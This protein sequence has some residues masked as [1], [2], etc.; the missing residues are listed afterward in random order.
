MESSAKSP[1][2]TMRILKY[3]FVVCA[4]L[5]VQVAIEI[6]VRPHQPVSQPIEIGI[7]IVALACIAVGFLV[8][9]FV[10]RAPE[11]TYQGNPALTP[12]KR[13]MT[14]GIMSLAYF[15]AC[16]LFGL[17]LHYLGARL[18]LVEFLFGAGIAAELFW[19][20]G[21]PPSEAQGN[22]SQD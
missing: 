8:P 19:S 14:K 6:P 1:A 9:R 7:T 20:P 13:W 4:F 10:F 5:F 16:I 3:A 21:T 12:L 11:S 2:L 18:W 15:E 17:L 22:L